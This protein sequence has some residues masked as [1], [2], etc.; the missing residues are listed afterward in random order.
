[1]IR[2]RI[3]VF[4]LDDLRVGEWKVLAKAER[5]LAGTEGWGKRPGPP[6]F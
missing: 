2:L 3:G 5:R 6:A 4:R 1:L